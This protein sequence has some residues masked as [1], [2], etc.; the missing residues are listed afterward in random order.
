MSCSLSKGNSPYVR[1]QNK[2]CL[3]AFLRQYL[4]VFPFSHALFKAIEA[5]ELSKLQLKE[6]LLD[7]GCGNGFFSSLFF[8]GSV[9]AGLDICKHNGKRAK[10]RN[11]Y[12]IVTV[13]DAR[14]LPYK[15]ESFKTALSVCVIEHIIE[16]DRVLSEVYRVLKRGGEF[17]F[18]VPS[19]LF[20]EHLF[21]PELF[22][23][24]RLKKLA[25]SYKRWASINLRHRHCYSPA[26]WRKLL[27]KNGLELVNFEY[28]MSKRVAQ[29]LDKYYVLSGLWYLITMTP[30]GKDLS[31]LLYHHLSKYLRTDNSANEGALLLIVAKKI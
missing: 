28:F 13:G 5:K 19:H 14:N 10:R 23:K 18:T 26:G 31:P 21:F 17:V 1:S 15:Q 30:F 11:V 4:T 3:S 8:S 24:L 22:N 2:V 9:Q 12:N 20:N 6:P 7:L 29:F 27:S 25:K 16:L